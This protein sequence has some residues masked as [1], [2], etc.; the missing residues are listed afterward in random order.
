M[1]KEEAYLY[2]HPAYSQRTKA[3]EKEQ[4]KHM[5][6]CQNGSAKNRSGAGWKVFGLCLD[7]QVQAR[8][9]LAC[10]LSVFLGFRGNQKQCSSSSSVLP[11]TNSSSSSSM[12]ASTVEMARGETRNDQTRDDMTQPGEGKTETTN[13]RRHERQHDQKRS[14]EG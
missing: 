9:C 14:R 13:Q 6:H 10:S 1:G 4:T 12:R 8:L 11:V 3:K 2:S 5:Q 7:F